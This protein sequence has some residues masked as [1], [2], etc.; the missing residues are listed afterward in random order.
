MPTEIESAIRFIHRWRQSP[1][2]DDASSVDRK[3]SDAESKQP[4]PDIAQVPAA[5][6]SDH[7]ISGSVAMDD[8]DMRPRSS[9]GSKGAGLGSGSESD[10]AH[11]ASVS[12]S[13]VLPPNETRLVRSLTG[14]STAHSVTQSPYAGGAHA[15]STRSR[16]CGAVLVHCRAGKSRSA[17]VVVAYIATVLGVSISLAV[18]LVKSRRK[19]TEPN[20]GFLQQLFAMEEAGLFARLHSELVHGHVPGSTGSS[21]TSSIPM[22]GAMSAAGSLHCC[23]QP[24]MSAS[25]SLL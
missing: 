12:R 3:A 11:R 16:R 25:A 5:S 9:S 7:N 23:S 22:S 2:E 10:G 1:L 13:P 14:S 24:R 20:Y 18:E 15:A 6:A 4:T 19:S 8:G 17:T 21:S